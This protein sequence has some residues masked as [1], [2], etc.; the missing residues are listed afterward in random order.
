MPSNSDLLPDLRNAT[1]V[2]AC[3]FKRNSSACMRAAP[4]CRVKL[5]RIPKFAI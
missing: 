3:G 5:A 1:L 4:W 2:Q